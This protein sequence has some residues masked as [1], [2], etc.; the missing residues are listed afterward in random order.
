M[1]FGVT[2]DG[3]NK[4]VLADITADFEAKERADI[5]PNA[6]VDPESPFGQLNGI[7]GAAVAE[8]W[9]V[10]EETYHTFDPNGAEG[11]ALVNISL[12][13]GTTKRPATQS[14]VTVTCN[15]DAGATAPQGA[16]IAISG[17]EDIEFELDADIT[18]PGGSP[19]DIEGTA[20][21]ID[22]GPVQAL[23]GQ[24]TV[25]KTPAAGWNS[26]T[27]AADAELGENADNDITLRARRQAQLALQGG[28]TID[29]IAADLLQITTIEDVLMLENTLDHFD[30]ITGLSGHTFEAII[31]DSGL[32]PDNT[33][34]QTI[35]NT[36]PGGI[37][38]AG[39]ASGIATD[40]AGKEHTVLFSRGEDRNIYVAMH[41]AVSSQYPSDG[42]TQVIAAALLKAEQTFGVA[43]DVVALALEVAAFGITGVTNA[44]ADIGFADGPTSAANLPIGL[45]QRAKFSSLHFTV[46]YD[47]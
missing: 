19:D 28:S 9:E 12:I 24:L 25:I 3:F 37:F 4:K 42:E 44:V 20:T 38:S 6:D 26:V 46:E 39:E 29:A 13:T 32:T 2:S 22:T 33:I 30:P 14:I 10:L 27:N 16:L 5:D 40:K 34:A 15:L 31:S 47:L 36:K 11:D 21:A 35:F 41:L 43:D 8:N 7:V 17:R 23:A 45:H 1:T 18:N